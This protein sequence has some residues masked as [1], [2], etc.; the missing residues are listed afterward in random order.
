[1]DAYA[2]QSAFYIIMGIIP[3][4]MLFLILLQYTPLTKADLMDALQNIFPEA[5]WDYLRELVN[6]IYI[7]NTAILSG[8]AIVSLWTTGR[9]VMAVTNGLN[10]IYGIKET[11][12]YVFCR[13]RAAIYMFLL[14]IILVLALG[15]LV[16]G[17]SFHLLLMEN[18]PVLQ[19]F[20]D[21]LI[22]ARTGGALFTL[23]LL[24]AALYKFLPNIKRKYV[25]QLP[26]AALASVSWSVFSYLISLYVEWKEKFA[27]IYGSLTM[28]VMIMLWLYFCMWLL[29]AGA[30]FNRFFEKLK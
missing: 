10:S 4:L 19:R 26:G 9:S 13:I 23:T 11:R 27:S 2:A 6:G 18:V 7:K 25:T 15:L 1:M 30:Q 3:F 17:N 16:F 14:L 22:W 21:L 12:N 20:S 5:F 28:V 24:I 29:F 8:T